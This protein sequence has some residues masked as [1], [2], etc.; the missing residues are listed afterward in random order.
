M[1]RGM[2]D[3]GGIRDL[4]GIVDLGGPFSRST[5]CFLV[6]DLGGLAQYEDQIL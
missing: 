1:P 2:V 5:L 4:G 6:I 3:L